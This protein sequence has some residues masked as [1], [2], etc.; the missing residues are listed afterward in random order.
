MTATAEVRADAFAMKAIQGTKLTYFTETGG[1]TFG[2]GCAIEAFG[3]A[4]V[5]S[6]AGATIVP[7]AGSPANVS[8]L[9]A[10][11]GYIYAGRYQEKSLG[12]HDT[13]T[14]TLTPSAQGTVPAGIQM[15][16]WA[17]F[18][19]GN[20]TVSV[21]L[22]VTGK[23]GIPVTIGCQ[24]TCAGSTSA[25]IKIAGLVGSIRIPT[26]A[27]KAHAPGVFTVKI[28]LSAS[29]RAKITAA[30]KA[31]KKVTATTTTKVVA[32]THSVTVAKVS[33]FTA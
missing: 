28:V 12:Y 15:Y 33:T 19:F 22:K 26:V 18:L 31:K 25:L 6:A 17:G 2:P 11:G 3:A 10:Q 1:T 13:G 21:P 14:P 23:G 9:F 16:S 24:Q 30:I 8:S 4:N 27:I 32:T 7:C 20:P 29:V 5:G